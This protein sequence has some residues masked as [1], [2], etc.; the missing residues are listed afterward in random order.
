MLHGG[1]GSEK[2]WKSGVESRV[3]I[4]R[5]EMEK[6]TQEGNTKG[7]VKKAEKSGEQWL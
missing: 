5:V 4:L 3:I 7:T 6:D 1:R 2:R